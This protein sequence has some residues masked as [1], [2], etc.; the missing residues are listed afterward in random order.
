ML[1]NKK[2]KKMKTKLFN[3]ACALICVL[4]IISCG[5]KSGQ[6]V[7]KPEKEKIEEPQP[8][9]EDDPSQQTIIGIPMSVCYS[10]DLNSWN[11]SL[12]AKSENGYAYNIE[13]DSL[14]AVKII[15]DKS[16][17]AVRVEGGKITLLKEEKAEKFSNNHP[18]YHLKIPIPPPQSARVKASPKN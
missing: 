9:L 13:I 12:D 3:S 1:T 6:R 18:G 4:I 15:Q 5:S 10:L 16:I 8:V 2:N 14:M 11:L 17:V 7:Q